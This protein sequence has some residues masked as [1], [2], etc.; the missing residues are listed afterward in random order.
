[1]LSTSESDDGVKLVGNRWI[2]AFAGMT[3][4]S[5]LL[6]ER[7]YDNLSYHEVYD[8]QTESGNNARSPVADGDR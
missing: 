2:P 5:A 6:L 7:W 3:S 4:L 8:G 1:M